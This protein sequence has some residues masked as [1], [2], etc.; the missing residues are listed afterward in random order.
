[1]K[2]IIGVLFIVDRKQYFAPLSSPKGKHIR[3]KNTLDLIKIKNGEYGVIN[4][5]NMIPVLENNYIEFDLN[6]KSNDKNEIF[7]LNLLRNQL[8]WLNS[9]KK[10]V[11]SKSKILYNL[12]KENKLPLNVKNRCCNFMLLEEKCMEYNKK[13]LIAI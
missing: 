11:F 2:T 3:L 12:Y 4:L 13:E 1:M 5:N 6:I 7:R 8:R 9:N 10:E